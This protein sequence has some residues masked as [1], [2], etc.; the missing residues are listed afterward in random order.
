MSTKSQL[1]DI[2]EKIGQQLDISDELF[3]KAKEKYQDMG[4]WLDKKTPEYKIDIYP[5]GSFALGTVIKPL[6]D[7]EEYDLDLVCEFKNGNNTDAKEL[8]VDIIKP[9][10]QEYGDCGEPEEKRRCWQ[11]IRV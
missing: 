5:Q 6:N 8:K 11:V 4:V 1:N 9:L 3:E 7:N 2:Y 10:L